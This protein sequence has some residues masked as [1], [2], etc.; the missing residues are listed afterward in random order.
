[1]VGGKEDDEMEDDSALEDESDA[2]ALEQDDKMNESNE[3]DTD[4]NFT[5]LK[6]HAEEHKKA[7]EELSE[8]DPEFYKYLQEQGGDLLDFDLS[9]EEGSDAEE[10][11]SESEQPK[12]DAKKPTTQNL[13]VLTKG[14]LKE[15]SSAIEASHDLKSFR[16]LLTAFKSAAR[17]SSEEEQTVKL[18]YKISDPGGNVSSR[19]AI[20]GVLNL[21]YDR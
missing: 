21:L 4:E 16:N 20:M 15:W 12:T 7:L 3:G 10:S 5:S 18:V 2:E 6:S 17:S 19:L 9:D 13:V 11:G 14:Q 1:M 8:L